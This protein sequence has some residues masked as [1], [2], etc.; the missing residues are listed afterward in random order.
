MR[1]I[2]L[3]T[4]AALAASTSGH[5]TTYL[6]VAEAQHVLFPGAACSPVALSL[7]PDQR[8]AIEHASGAHNG[9]ALEVWRVAGGGWFVVDRVIGKHEYITYA[10]GLDA[11]GAIRGVEILDYRESYG[12]E[13][14]HKPWRA[15]FVGKTPHDALQL[16]RDIKNISGAT[17]SCRHVTE[18]VKRIVAT[19]DLVLRQLG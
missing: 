11:N 6:S 15:Q 19:Y 4:P 9:P 16:G 17:L 13:I 18:G 3:L 1:A 14:R 10:V 7:T 5:A 8:A 12:G 2:W